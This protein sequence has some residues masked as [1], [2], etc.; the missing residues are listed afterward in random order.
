MT[1]IIVGVTFALLSAAAMEPWARFL[2][3]Y[4]W[5][6]WLWS[7]HRSHHEPK[8]GR[9]EAN[10]WLSVLHAPIAAG[11]IIGGCQASGVLRGALVGVGVGMTAF[12]ALYLAIHDGLIH[13]RL[14]LHALLRFRYFRRVRGA[15]LVHHRAG[16][17]PF[18]LFLGPRELRGSPLSPRRAAA[19]AR[20]GRGVREQ[21]AIPSADR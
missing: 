3:H 1:T 20:R 8:R 14:R 6:R 4:A 18:G 7:L 2:H 13:G 17:A 15:H 21:A 19:R 10:D 5:H 9:F 11:M 16:G 12:G